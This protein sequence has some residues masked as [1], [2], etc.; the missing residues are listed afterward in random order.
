MY[1]PGGLSMT[2]TFVYPNVGT[3]VAEMRLI[4]AEAAARSNDLTAACNQL[5]DVRKCRFAP[6]DY[7][8]FDSTDQESVL[9]TVLKERIFE[10]PFHGMR[11]FDMRRLAA[12]GRMETVTRLDRNGVVAATLEPNSPRYTLQIPM[13]V[14]IFNPNW[15][16]NP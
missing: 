5:H 13:Q 14:M 9:T 12:E 7:V 1:W 8:R 6:A 16:Q 4:L 10:F 15:K 11:W 2:G 3:S